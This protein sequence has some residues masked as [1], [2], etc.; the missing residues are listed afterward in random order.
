[1]F[2]GP[3]TDVS[4]LRKFVTL[5]PAPTEAKWSVARIGTDDVFGPSDTD[6]WAVMRY[7]NADFRTISQA[8]E[9]GETPQAATVGTL[10]G[11][12][13]A[14]VDL[15]RF[16]QG[17]NYVFD[18]SLSSA[19]PFESNIYSTGFAMPLSDRRVLIHFSSR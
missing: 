16:R 11:W 15:T 14:E 18:K 2:E 6:F 3:Q 9:A 10:P 19:A 12:V 13:S 7:S 4:T 17:S 5:Q 8:L 1:M